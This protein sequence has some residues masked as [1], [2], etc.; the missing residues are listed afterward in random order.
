LPV[1]DEG[2]PAEAASGAAPAGVAEGPSKAEQGSR[3]V[4]LQAEALVTAPHACARGACL[5]S[6]CMLDTS[7]LRA[8]LQACNASA[9][10]TRPK[11]PT[12]LLHKQRKRLPVH[13]RSGLHKYICFSCCSTSRAPCHRLSS[14]GAG[15][16]ILQH[17]VL[18]A[19]A[20]CSQSASHDSGCAR[21]STQT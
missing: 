8:V 10:P 12:M 17:C 19:T 7:M 18:A 16:H 13:Q 3:S 6:S 5:T 1:A 4:V 11:G 15:A 14:G 20:L 2:L 21:C 9:G